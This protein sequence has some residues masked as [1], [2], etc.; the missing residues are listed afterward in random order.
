MCRGP[1]SQTWF[2][3]MKSQDSIDTTNFIN[4]KNHLNYIWNILPFFN[5]MLHVII[6]V[7]KNIVQHHIV[8]SVI[9]FIVDFFMFWAIII[10][11]NICDLKNKT[12]LLLKFKDAPSKKTVQCHYIKRGHCSVLRP[13]TLI[14]F[15]IAQIQYKRTKQRVQNDVLPSL[16][17]LFF[18]QT[19]IVYL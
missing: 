13:S 7:C 9:S 19:M 1:D 10:C 14:I 15:T 2:N 18:C 5:R 8:W 17:S 4:I 6:F 11:K 12:V 16:S 3:H